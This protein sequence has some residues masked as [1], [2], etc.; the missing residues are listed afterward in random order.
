MVRLGLG[1]SIVPRSYADDSLPGLVFHRIPQMAGRLQIDAI[2]RANNPAAGLRRVIEDVLHDF[3][4]EG[5]R[6]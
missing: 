5:N 3:S 1:V 2:W 4:R 6:D